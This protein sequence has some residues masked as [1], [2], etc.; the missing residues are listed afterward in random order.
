MV[1]SGRLQDG[2]SSQAPGERDGIDYFGRGS[3]L[4]SLQERFSLVA[5]RSMYRLWLAYAGDV[6]GQTVLDVGSTP[7]RERR[8]SNCMLPWFQASGVRLSLYSPEDIRGIG[9]LFPYATILPSAGFGAPL[10]VP[11][12][13]FD[14]TVSSAVLEHVGGVEAQVAFIAD[15]ARTARGLF[16]T[17]PNRWHWLEFHTKL[18]LLHWLPRP[19]HRATLRALGRTTWSQE[20]HLRLVGATELTALARQALGD[21]FTFELRHVWSLGMPSNLVLLARRRA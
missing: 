20:S 4:T 1:G 3:V 6:K 7:D 13:S 18:P 2:P 14:W 19:T 21:A 9:D 11:E 12:R 5:R 16:L 8:D 15:C 10:P 17:T